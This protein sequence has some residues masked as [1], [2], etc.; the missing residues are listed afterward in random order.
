MLDG[1]EHPLLRE[2]FVARRYEIM[3]EDVELY[4]HEAVFALTGAAKWIEKH[5]VPRKGPLDLEA[6]ALLLGVPISFDDDKC[7]AALGVTFGLPGT[8][9]EDQP[10]EVAIREDFEQAR[11]TFG[12]EVGHIFLGLA[13]NMRHQ[14]SHPVEDFCDLFGLELAMPLS[15]NIDAVDVN[16][17][18]LLE[19]SSK[20]GVR[21]SEVIKQFIRKGLLPERLY[22]DS[23]IDWGLR[24]GSMVRNAVCMPC[25]RDYG[26]CKGQPPPERILRF[27]DH[28]FGG[29]FNVCATEAAKA[30]LMT[31]RS[32]GRKA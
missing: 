1:R 8:N 4:G 30:R 29:H 27:S 12:H 16:E 6:T 10:L 5:R 32:K 9:G 14:R 22:V 15:E 28:A 11:V 18:L 3:V 24:A 23:I 26:S 20:F 2:A 25:Q 17:E 21:M 13:L 19:Y 31:P 7:G